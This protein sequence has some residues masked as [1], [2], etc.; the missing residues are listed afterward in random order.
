MDNIISRISDG[1]ILRANFFQFAM[2]VVM[3][4]CGA[5]LLQAKKKATLTAGDLSSSIEGED[6]E[7][8]NVGIALIVFGVLQ[9]CIYFSFYISTNRLL[10]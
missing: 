4:T 10:L 2:A 3:I 5:F 8:K 9:L 1:S 6:V 7:A